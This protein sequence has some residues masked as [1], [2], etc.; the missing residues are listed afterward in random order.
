M[1]FRVQGATVSADVSL[2]G[3]LPNITYMVDLT[4]TPSG[5]G[6]NIYTAA[7]ATNAQGDGFVHLTQPLSSGDTGAFVDVF[8]RPSF[9]FFNSPAIRVG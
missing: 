9:D 2:R 7:L 8:Y 5:T 6:C 1:V 3:A 4:Q